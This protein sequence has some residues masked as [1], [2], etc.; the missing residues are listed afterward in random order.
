MN[1]ERK[2]QSVMRVLAN[3]NLSEWALEYWMSVYVGLTKA[4]TDAVTEVPAR[5]H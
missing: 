1:Y 4:E 3:P 2:R 5:I